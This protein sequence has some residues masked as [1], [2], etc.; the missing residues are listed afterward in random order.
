M[1][2]SVVADRVYEWDGDEPLHRPWNETVIYEAHVRGLTMT[3]PDVPEDL[4][5]TYAGLAC[6]PVLD[7]LTNLG[8]TA[9]ELLPVHHFV[10]ESF[11]SHGCGP[12][13]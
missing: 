5:G 3:H 13:V 1:P 4:R 8:V 7:H 12:S 6:Q 11:L 2:E 9:V 10:D